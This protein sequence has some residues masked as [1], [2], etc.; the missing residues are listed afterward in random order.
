[1][2]RKK[3]PNYYDFRD[4]GYIAHP[5]SHSRTQY[6]IYGISL[7]ENGSISIYIR[8]KKENVISL[9]F[10]LDPLEYYNNIYYLDINSKNIVKVFKVDSDNNVFRKFGL[11]EAIN[12]SNGVKSIEI[13]EESYLRFKKLFDLFKIAKTDETFNIIY[14]YCNS[15]LQ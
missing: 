2:G 13:S 3:V 1:M 10:D 5:S 11:L 4:S 15:L 7:Y 9:Y 12:P 14:D 6:R 8:I